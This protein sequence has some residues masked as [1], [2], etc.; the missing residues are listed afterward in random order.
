[1][2]AAA[3]AAAAA[4]K[5]DTKTLKKLSSSESSS[6]KSVRNDPKY[7]KYVKMQKMGIPQ[8]A[9]RHKMIQDGL[10]TGDIDAFFE[11]EEPVQKTKIEE[12]KPK[13]NLQKDPKFSKYAK[14]KKMGIPDGAVRQKMLQEGV[15]G[16][17][18][19]QFFGINSNKEKEKEK[20]E[21][22]KEEMKKKKALLR[23]E[24]R[25]KKYIKMEKMGIPEGAIRHK[26]MIE[27][28]PEGDINLFFGRSLQDSAKAVQ[29]KTI[30]KL[31]M[32]KLRWNALPEV[33]M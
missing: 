5:I 27:N 24:D 9:V 10:E 22:N 28:I 8:G 2:I 6:K 32:T 21:E 33:C 30:P 1:M 3:A 7:T 20:E 13:K 19:D 31:N 26:M 29:K 14:M 23:G 16:S 25:F 17:D 11:G 4:T 18:I 15:S 12:E